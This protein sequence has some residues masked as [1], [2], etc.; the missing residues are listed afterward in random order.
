MNPVPGVRNTNQDLLVRQQGG[1]YVVAVPGVLV[2]VHGPLGT[3][4]PVTTALPLRNLAL[5]SIVVV[6]AAAAGYYYSLATLIRGVTV[7]SPLAYLGLVPFIALALVVAR[8]LSPRSEPDI[9]D[10]HVDY[11]I[12]LPLIL[13]ALALVLILPVHQSTFFWLWRLDLF[14]MP[15]FV[16]GA[17]CVVFGLRAL[18]RF[19]FPVAFL[20]LAWPLPFTTILSGLLAGFTELTTNALDL[21]TKVL[22]LAQPAAGYDGSTFAVSHAGQTFLV[23]VAS[24][25]SGVNGVVGFLL[26]GV[27][28]GFLVR[29]PLLTKAMWLIAGMLLVWALNVIR[30]LA[31]FAV[32]HQ[33][34]EAV[35]L[36]WV[37]PIAGLAFFNLGVLAMLL[38]MPRLGLHLA[39]GR[40]PARSRVRRPPAAF[41][42]RR[43]AVPQAGI[44]CT[45]VLLAGGLGVFANSHLQQYQLVAQDLGPPRLSD[46]SVGNAA[47]PGWSLTQVESLTWARQYFGPQSTWIRYQ[48]DWQS[49]ASPPSPFRSGQPV[50]M[51]VISTDDLFSFS[52]YGLS[53]CYQFHGYQVMDARTVSLAGG[54]TGHAIT[55]YN[56]SINSKWI[57]LYWEWPVLGGANYR[58]ERVILNLLNPATEQ[59]VAP[60][61]DA[62]LSSGPQLFINDLVQGSSEGSLSSGLIS[63][64]NFMVGF[65]NQVVTSAAS[66]PGQA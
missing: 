4:E 1:L 7:D 18:W 40:G 43:L 60:S 5:R 49:Q 2:H 16:A 10:R 66:H 6:G 42:R 41:Q 47:I 52:T 24:A 21:I 50:V 61:L 36:D 32:G 23:A 26:I 58:Y 17:I 9:H 59:I 8:G 45:L 51:D 57:A 65:A 14:S 44:A 54:V 33:W 62:S 3:P 19:R 27:A 48:Y 31:V 12:G 28:F 56:P 64:R 13:L 15:F 22:P 55:Y 35:A 53:A 29:G 25:C 20:F 39:T 11:I 38:A 63:A 37:H 34:G 46:L 30:I